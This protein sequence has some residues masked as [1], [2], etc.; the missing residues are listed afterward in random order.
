MNKRCLNI[1]TRPAHDVGPGV[2]VD[3]RFCSRKCKDDFTA[4]ARKLGQ[5]V[6]EAL[7]DIRAEAEAE[8]NSSDKITVGV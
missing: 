1:L 3:A 4:G 2:R 8:R 5:A 6:G 7:F